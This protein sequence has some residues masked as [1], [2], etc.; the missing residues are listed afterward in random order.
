[1]DFLESLAQIKS[2]M[3]KDNVQK[4][5]NK[6]VAKTPQISQPTK[7]DNDED[8]SQKQARLEAEFMEYIKNSDIKKL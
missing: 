5:A 8:I 6:K 7:Q 4:T 3:K 2:E 1:M